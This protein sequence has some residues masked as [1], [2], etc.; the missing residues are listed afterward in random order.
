MTAF[1]CHLSGI[2]PNVATTGFLPGPRL[3]LTWMHLRGPS[4]VPT[5]ALYFRAIFD[6]VERCLFARESSSD[7]CMTQ[8]SLFSRHTSWARVGAVMPTVP[9]L[10]VT[11]LFPRYDW[12]ESGWSSRTVPR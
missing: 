11:L 1:F 10:V 5:A 4:G 6:M 9:A 12:Q 8:W 3:M 7:D 2:P